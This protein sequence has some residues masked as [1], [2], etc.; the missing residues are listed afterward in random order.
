MS[1]D[2]EIVRKE[3]GIDKWLVFGGS[4]GSALGLDYALRFPDRCLGLIIRGIFL[5]TPEEH[6]EVY[7]RKAFAGF[8]TSVK[9]FQLKQFDA[10]YQYASKRWSVAKKR[11]WALTSQSGFAGSM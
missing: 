1:A 8:D 10:F 3:L 4:W 11:H 9:Q 7:A 5:G 2:F 6:D